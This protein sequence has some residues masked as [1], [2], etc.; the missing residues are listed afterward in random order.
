LFASPVGGTRLGKTVLV[1]L[2]DTA[3]P[4]T[5]E[6]YTVKRYE[7]QKKAAGDSWR[8]AKIT[9]KPNNPDFAPIMLGGADEGQIQVIAEFL[10][11]L[12]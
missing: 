1:Q 3:D 7:S 11:V 5:G 6:R 10:E 4:E 12:R 8:H 9:L 2:R